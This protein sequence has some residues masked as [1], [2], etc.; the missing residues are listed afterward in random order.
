MHVVRILEANPLLTKIIVTPPASP[1][2]PLL[3]F[4]KLSPVKIDI[5]NVLHDQDVIDICTEAWGLPSHAWT[6]WDESDVNTS[7]LSPL[8]NGLDRLFRSGSLITAWSLSYLRNNFEQ[9]GHVEQWWWKFKGRL[10]TVPFYPALP[11]LPINLLLPPRVRSLFASLCASRP[12]GS[13]D[14]SGALVPDSRCMLMDFAP[15]GLL[16]AGGTP[17]SRPTGVTST[18]TSITPCPVLNGTQASATGAL[19]QRSMTNLQFS[20]GTIACPLTSFTGG[21]PLLPPSSV[22]QHISGDSVLYTDEPTL[23]LTGQLKRRTPDQEPFGDNK[24]HNHAN[25]ETLEPC[26]NI[27]SVEAPPSLRDSLRYLLNMLNGDSSPIPVLTSTDWDWA[28]GHADEHWTFTKPPWHG[29][30]SIS[31]P[32]LQISSHGFGATDRWRRYGVSTSP[33]SLLLTTILG[34][35]YCLSRS[36]ALS[37]Q[38]M[39][40]S[41]CIMPSLPQNLLSG[42]VDPISALLPNLWAL[43]YHACTL[44]NDLFHSTQQ[45][46]FPGKNRISI[47]RELL[48]DPTLQMELDASQTPFRGPICNRA[49]TFLRSPSTHCGLIDV[50]V[51]AVAMGVN[52]RFFYPDHWVGPFGQT[53]SIVSWLQQLANSDASVATAESAGEALAI[54]R[55][56]MSEFT[57]NLALLNAQLCF[58]TEQ[59]STLNHWVALLPRSVFLQSESTLS[60]LRLAPRYLQL[61]WKH[62]VANAGE[63]HVVEGP[64]LSVLEP[65]IGAD[66]SITSPVTGTTSGLISISSCE[67]P[68]EQMRSRSAPEVGYVILAE[69][70]GERL[71]LCLVVSTSPLLLQVLALSQAKAGHRK[72]RFFPMDQSGAISP[73]RKRNAPF[74]FARGARPLLIREGSF[75]PSSSYEPSLSLAMMGAWKNRNNVR[76]QVNSAHQ[77]SPEALHFAHPDTSP[78]DEAGTEP[79]REAIHQCLQANILTAISIRELALAGTSGTDTDTQSISPRQN[80]TLH[81]PHTPL[82]PL[83]LPRAGSHSTT[84][85]DPAT[86]SRSSVLVASSATTPAITTDNQVAG[87]KE[88]IQHLHLALR[89]A[90]ADS[91]AKLKS[92]TQ[93]LHTLRLEKEVLEEK[94]LNPPSPSLPQ[95]VTSHAHQLRVTRL[96]QALAREIAHKQSLTFE[97]DTLRHKLATSNAQLFGQTKH[98]LEAQNQAQVPKEQAHLP[99]PSRATQTDAPLPEH[100]EG[101][102]N[103]HNEPLSG[104]APDHN[105]TRLVQQ[106]LTE[107]SKL[108]QAHT[109]PMLSRSQC[110]TQ[111]RSFGVAFAQTEIEALG[112]TETLKEMLLEWRTGGTWDLCSATFQ[113]K[114]FVKVIFTN[115]TDASDF[116]FRTLTLHLN[117]W[118]QA[119]ASSDWCP[120]L[121]PPLPTLWKGGLIDAGYKPEELPGLVVWKFSLPFEKA[122]EVVRHRTLTRLGCTPQQLSLFVDPQFIFEPGTAVAGKFTTTVKVFAH[123]SSIASKISRDPDGTL[124]KEVKLTLTGCDICRAEGHAAWA[125]PSPKIR[126]RLSRPCNI[127]IKSYLRTLLVSPSG[128]A[129]GLLNIWGGR[130]PM[131]HQ[132]N[133][134]FGYLAFESIAARD[135]GIRILHLN[136]TKLPI[137]LPLLK[138]DGPMIM[139]CPDCGC[140]TQ[141]PPAYQIKVHDVLAL[142]QRCPNLPVSGNTSFACNMDTQ[143]WRSQF[144]QRPPAHQGDRC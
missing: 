36:L 109:D 25:T 56:T 125:C 73:N 63:L 47:L 51:L 55:S 6:I 101:K 131:L 18:T 42:Q 112:G 105:I 21:G 49:L 59:T 2:A 4:S 12:D 89:K 91:E 121:N 141:E 57:P 124:D 52:V 27:T 111:F 74:S 83:T 11:D 129:V 104:T 133:K 38:I 22:G 26:I 139:E 37:L 114:K 35:G 1:Q 62:Q 79:S 90:H 53:S 130:N 137:V 118:C 113:N 77:K 84:H 23:K 70:S 9:Q 103:N 32:S 126:I 29:K 140:S 78:T 17:D 68:V 24:R 46:P 115:I 54:I 106:F 85:T 117:A 43:L 135:N 3:P 93:Q 8:P 128:K 66:A 31:H 116:F 75:V 60:G 110:E 72:N 134:R 144:P 82:T 39:S 107:Q 92:V 48:M 28:E 143:N 61:A 69:V 100:D 16:G 86:T 7:P 122:A 88:T 40:L 67:T 138:I 119:P 98:L 123:F 50:L 71:H 45:W 19:T 120:T 13:P 97:N 136:I 102:Q 34:D 80:A 94:L 142:R 65:D 81:C 15:I 20:S 96:K 127:S 64:H 108:V 10:I 76:R 87:L 95:P 14:Y 5:Q 33:V 30:T 44:T 58:H 132:Q 41:G 99:Q